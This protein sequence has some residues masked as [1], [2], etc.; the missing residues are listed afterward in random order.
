MRTFRALLVISLLSVFA[1]RCGPLPA[2]VTLNLADATQPDMN[3]I[4]QSTFRALTAQAAV[5]PSRTPPPSPSTPAAATGSISGQLNYPADSM[6]ALY[7]TAFRSGSQYYQ[8]VITQPGQS[9]YEIDGL[10][11]GEYQV[12]AYT[13]GGGGFPSDL[14]GGFTLAVKCG[15]TSSCTD[16]SLINVPVQAGQTTA[17]I[18]PDDW[19]APQGAFPSFPQQGAAARIATLPPAVADGS[20]SGSLMYPASGIPALRI[21]AFQ[22]GGSAYYFL[23]TGLGQTSYQL[24][25]VPPGTYHVVAYPLPGAGFTG[26]PSGGYSQMVPCG[27]QNGCTDHTLI[28]VIVT[29]GRVTTGANPNDYYASPGTFPPDPVP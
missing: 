16:H 9:T 7:V 13:V 22:V 15:L 23:N 12:I 2:T 24:D 1:T 11:A 10:A 26:G 8:Y 6:P 14:P 29:A 17:G 21:V 3:Q 5:E 18:D 25:H 20:I 19:Y 4:V 27:L 28:D